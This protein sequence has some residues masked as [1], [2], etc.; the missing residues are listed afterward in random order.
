VQTG[1]D[2]MSLYLQ[3]HY[4]LPTYHMR[5]YSLRLD[6]F[7]SVNAPFSGGEMVTKPLTFSGQKLVINYSTSSIGHVKVE[8][9]DVN[10]A[11]IPGFA[12]VD[13]DEIVGDEIRRT[14]TWKDSSDVSA[15]AG[16]AIRLRFE[17]KDADLYSIQFK[18]EEK[19]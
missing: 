18:M 14:V 6:G 11:P 7:A 15:L 2:E 17:M 1:P 4:M 13:A 3:K 10:G 16:Q 8:L 9:Q 19:H 12:L 5:R